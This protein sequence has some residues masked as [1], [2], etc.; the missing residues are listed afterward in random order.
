MTGLPPP[1]EP[2]AQA[3]A[4]AAAAVGAGGGVVGRAPSAEIPSPLLVG[5][6]LASPSPI[7]RA[8][9]AKKPKAERTAFSPHN[10]DE[11]LYGHVLEGNN[12]DPG[13]LVL[14]VPTGASAPKCFLTSRMSS[15]KKIRK[16]ELIHSMGSCVVALG[17]PN[18]LHGHTF[19]FVA[20][21]VG[22]QL[23]STFLKPTNGGALVAF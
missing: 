13:A 22:D 5:L 7:S 8:I 2:V 20:E 19:A 4:D 1:K 12:P 15:A 11:Q 18:D 10:P 16:I 14:M 9:W 21:Q 6:P 3:D 17:Q 23:P